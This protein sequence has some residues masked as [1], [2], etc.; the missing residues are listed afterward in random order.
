[1]KLLL[2]AFIYVLGLQASA[3]VPAHLVSTHKEFTIRSATSFGGWVYYNCDSVENAV[4]D[5][6]TKLG[7]SNIRVWCTGGLQD[8]QPPMDAYVDVSFD[9]LKLAAINDTGIVMA[10]WTPIKIHTWDSCELETEIFNNTRSGF[11]MTN[12]AV[13]RCSSSTSQFRASLTTL[14]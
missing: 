6:L 8:N 2:I 5:L 9:A 3:D 4:T 14:F 13:S 1:M 7:A 11:S 12:V 10:H